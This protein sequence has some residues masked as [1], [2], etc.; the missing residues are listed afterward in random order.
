MN[1]PRSVPQSKISL[2]ELEP[3]SL[4]INEASGMPNAAYIDP[5]LFEFERDT[6]FTTS[7]VAIGFES[8]I[9]PAMVCPIDFMGLPILLT[10]NK[11]GDVSVFHNVCSHRGMKLVDETRT[12]NGLVVCPYHSW[13]Y[14]LEGALKATPHI[15]GVGIHKI[16]GY[17][18]ENKGLK[19]IRSHIWMGVIFI[20]LDGEAKPFE[21]DAE[22]AIMR[23]KNLMGESGEQCLVAPEQDGD[24]TMEVNCN[25]KL[26]IENYLEA[27]HLPFIHPGLNQYSPLSEHY[28]DIYSERSSGQITTTFDP[29]LDSENPLPLFPDWDEDRLQNGDYPAVYPN[30]LLGFQ[31][32]H[33]FAMIIH[34]LTTDKSREQLKIFYVNE[35]AEDLKYDAARKAN[36]QDWATVFNED[37]GP[38]ER[39]QI[40]RKSPAYCGGAFSPELDR[41]S[42][43]FHQ[44]ISGFYLTHA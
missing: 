28:C 14:D 24:L 22:V 29:K 17:H 44:W 39:M 7:W 31:A 32:N 35:G 2:N 26:V 30:L 43:H 9:K 20:N 25:W 11:G 12:T 3:V 37:I 41:C 16:D 38:C 8:Q 36:L 27:Y 1:R 6:I 34:P 4:P 5:A 13:T 15:G 23:A 21:L 33:V 40:G 10:K 19:V 42:H 18:C